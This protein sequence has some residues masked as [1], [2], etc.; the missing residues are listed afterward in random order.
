MQ[1]ISSV[2]AADIFFSCQAT[3][4]FSSGY[5]RFLDCCIGNQP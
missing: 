4:T 1:P 3:F 5:D 2:L